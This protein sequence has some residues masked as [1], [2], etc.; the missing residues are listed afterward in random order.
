EGGG[1]EGREGGGGG[2]G[3]RGGGT[4]APRQRGGRKGGRRAGAPEAGDVTVGE[5]TPA[6]P[7]AATFAELDLPKSI[8]SAL[9]REGVT[10]PFPIQGATLPDSIAGRDVLGRGRTGSGK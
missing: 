6:R 8:L 5:G 10:E 9:T 2:G 1:R 7:P 4:G 3:K